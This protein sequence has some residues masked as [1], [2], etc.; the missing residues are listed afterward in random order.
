MDRRFDDY[1]FQADYGQEQDLYNEIVEME[2]NSIWVP[3]ITSKDIV[4]LGLDDSPLFGDIGSDEVPMMTF[5]ECMRYGIAEDLLDETMIRGQKLVVK[6]SHTQGLMRNTAYP[7]LCETAKINGAAL[8]R[9]FEK[10]HFEFA[11][12]MN[13]ALSVAKGTTLALERYGKISA[14]HSSADGG[15]EVMPISKLFE[16]TTSALKDR[17]GT[18]DFQHGSNSHGYTSATWE[19]PD[20]RDKILTLYQDAVQAKNSKYAINFMPAV[21]FASSDT[22]ISCATLEPVFVMPSG[23]TTGFVDPIK[24]KHSKRGSSNGSK[25]PIEVFEEEADTVWAKFEESAK[26]ISELS[27]ITIYNG[28]N[29]VVSLCKKYRIPKKYGEA[30]RLE[31]ERLTSG[32][33][34]TITAHDLYLAMTEIVAEAMRC[35][36]ND[37]TISN[38]SEAVNKVLKADWLEHDVGGMVAWGNAA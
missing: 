26:A 24:V 20:A 33:D 13:L 18:I 5:A 35:D 9:L 16:I 19:L 4:I 10:N 7:S 21:R 27:N 2:K 8:G 28:C 3:G 32:G 14:L 17:F 37:R 36:A 6:L 23:A 31:V 29:C 30:A 12:M 38:L 25:T 1:V 22:A 11:E 34:P 15:Y